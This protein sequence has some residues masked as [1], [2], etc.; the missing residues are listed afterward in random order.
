M[1]N[2]LHGRDELTCLLIDESE[3]LKSFQVEWEVFNV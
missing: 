2:I 1:D 3:Q